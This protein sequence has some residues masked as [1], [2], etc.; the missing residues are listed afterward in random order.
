[1]GTKLMASLNTNK[2]SKSTA[3]QKI[4]FGV[5]SGLYYGDGQ[6]EILTVFEG[7]DIFKYISSKIQLLPDL[8]VRPSSP[9]VLASVRP[10]VCVIM[11]T[12]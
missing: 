8:Q 1:M 2:I 5:K 12:L 3:Q 11:K 4:R 10:C 6:M 7:S 9:N